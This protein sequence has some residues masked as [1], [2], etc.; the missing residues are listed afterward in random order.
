MTFQIL[1]LDPAPFSHL[2][3]C[4][5]GALAN[6]RVVPYEANSKPGFPCRVSL[7]DAE[8]G[9]RL[10]LINHEHLPAASPYRSAHAIFVAE[11]AQ[12]A[13]I[14]PGAV[15]QMIASR[16]VSVRVFDGAGMMLDAELVDGKETAA[17]LTR[18]LGLEGAAEAHIHSAA[19]G[20]YLAKA[21]S[22]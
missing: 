14:E 16:M 7:V 5:A 18:L 10:F 11:G 2:S 19:R 4:D 6:L 22:I 13:Q 15:P 3:G 20:C 12:A 1:P 8:P 17:A 21:I 9:T